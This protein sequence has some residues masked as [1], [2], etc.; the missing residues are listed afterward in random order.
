MG[1]QR[2]TWLSWLYRG[3]RRLK[4]GAPPHVTAVGTYNASFA[5]AALQLLRIT[6]Q[7]ICKDPLHNGA[8]Q[9]VCNALVAFHGGLQARVALIDDNP[10]TPNMIRFMAAAGR[11]RDKLVLQLEH[12]FS[13]SDVSQIAQA[14]VA[15]RSLVFQLNN[16]PFLKRRFSRSMADGYCAIIPLCEG[17]SS[18]GV[19][20]MATC[21]TGLFT[22][23]VLPLFNDVGAIISKGLIAAQK[24]HEGIAAIQRLQAVSRERA[25][26]ADISQLMFRA[27]SEE[28]ILNGGCRALVAAGGYAQAWVV[29]ITDNQP[30]LLACGHDLSSHHADSAVA[31]QAHPL[32]SAIS[33]NIVTSYRIADTTPLQK[34]LPGIATKTEQC[35]AIPL[36]DGA[37]P[38]G[39][40][41]IAST[42]TSTPPAYELEFLK[43][44]ARGISFGITSLRSRRARLA[45]ER[46]RHEVTELLRNAIEGSNDF[47]YI[48]DL[49]GRYLQFINY[50]GLRRYGVDP[51][52][53]I[54]RTPAQ[55]WGTEIGRQEHDRLHQIL[56]RGTMVQ[57]NH[58]LTDKN[59]EKR[60]FWVTNGP[61]RSED[62]RLQ[63]VFGVLRDV[64]DFR[65]A[66]RVL[67][68][69]SE[70]LEIL[71]SLVNHDFESES[72]LIRTAMAEIIRLT[73]SIVGFF[74]IVEGSNLRI[75]MQVRR[76]GE[77]IDA[78]FL[79]KPT[80][81]PVKST[82]WLECATEGR[83]QVVNSGV[84]PFGDDSIRLTMTR[85][86]CVPVMVNNNVQVLAGVANKAD[87][88]DEIDLQQI[89]LFMDSLWQLVLRRRADQQSHL[90]L[91]SNEQS[92]NSVL[93]LD[94]TGIV[95]YVNRSFEE[96][97][98]V[99][100]EELLG[101]SI[102][103]HS[104][105]TM[106]GSDT[107]NYLTN[108]LNSEEVFTGELIKRHPDG[109][110]IICEGSIYPVR[111]SA[112]VITHYTS[113]QRDV[114]A[115]RDLRSR[116]EQSQKLEMVGHLTGGIAHDFNNLLQVINGY[117]EYL[118]HMI[119]PGGTHREEIQEIFDAGQRASQVTGRLLAFSRKQE[120]QRKQI[121]INL[122]IQDFEKMLRRV[123]G[124]TIEFCANLD[125]LVPDCIVDVSQIEQVLLNLTVNAR[126]AMPDGG[127]FT[128][129]TETQTIDPIQA[130]A[131]KMTPGETVV[132][133]VQD[134][135]TGMPPEVLEQ[136]FEPFFT[137][138]ASGKGTGLG[139][140]T[141]Y[142]IIAQHKGHISYTSQP[143]T[144]TCCR[145]I[146]PARSTAAN[147]PSEKLVKHTTDLR[148]DG[149]CILIGEDEEQV[150]RIMA[151]T[152][153]AHGYTVL[154]A[155]DGNE[156]IDIYKANSDNIDM[157]ICDICMPNKGGIEMVEEL[158]NYGRKPPILFVTGYADLADNFHTGDDKNELLIKPI[159]T[160]DLLQRV[161]TLL[162]T[163]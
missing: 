132:I 78:P 75:H 150:R 148:G 41:V 42:T 157:I 159:A 58:I 126:D 163:R 17:E 90:L 63:G 65:R 20:L 101:T 2:K 89:Q 145:I 96:M 79:P 111:N 64:T 93:I 108:A 27:D 86:A 43:E 87:N 32:L 44:L 4:S 119:P 28:A 146:L 22:D 97:N 6:S 3:K 107:C 153:I 104:F 149:Q 91:A 31:H 13:I 30:T 105:R 57:A 24:E 68:I 127:T 45:A 124:E 19:L 161:K 100:R 155:I 114:T 138:K 74:N 54:G 130:A 5:D 14:L 84:I 128:I 144:G 38:L 82:P 62:G 71:Q 98:R 140:A 147:V 47:I 112:G 110:S 35:I 7:A 103:S 109:T 70:R 29:A 21:E 16:S 94:A 125:P 99:R 48:I 55:V 69:N 120:T 39:S 137:T 26:L 49:Q 102:A 1:N 129:S 154:E 118:L 25:V 160:R 33:E 113:V 139:L 34:W 121:N 46:K 60:H 142:G 123:V 81:L 9:Q 162:A 12:P 141:V 76:G 50:N 85:F 72:E 18:L 106:V 10:T 37:D 56:A 61:L 77:I 92:M 66:E 115:E 136:L 15:R 59:G 40:F 95:T 23:A 135:G 117:A 67:R 156:V 73:D 134:T 143:D 133:T 83:T 152:L 122:L 36:W 131:L 53:V 116:L 151:Q 80:I 158:T 88:Y 52:N 11:S 51:T 8:L